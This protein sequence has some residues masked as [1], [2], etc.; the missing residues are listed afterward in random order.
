MQRLIDGR[1][2]ELRGG[3]VLRSRLICVSHSHEMRKEDPSRLS[4]VLVN[5][6]QT[7][8]K[9]VI[10]A[11]ITR[12]NR[13]KPQILSSQK[14]GKPSIRYQFACKRRKTIYALTLS[15]SRICVLIEA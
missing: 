11:G 13:A 14:A 5:G 6:D 2:A 3:G 15:L 9:V 8:K 7:V 12:A 4:I 10:A 1:S